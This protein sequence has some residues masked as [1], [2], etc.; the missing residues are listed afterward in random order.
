MQ[1]WR[2]R[3]TEF[4]EQQTRMVFFGPDL[5]CVSASLVESPKPWDTVWRISLPG[6]NP[7]GEH[8][9]AQVTPIDSVNTLSLPIN[10]YEG[11]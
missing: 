8:A 5:A 1:E 7:V 6:R 10:W 11:Y 3:F 2:T 4:H 9:V